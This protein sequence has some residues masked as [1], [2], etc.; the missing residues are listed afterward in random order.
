VLRRTIGY[1]DAKVPLENFDKAIFEV[2]PGGVYRLEQKL[3]YRSR[4]QIAKSTHNASRF[5]DYDESVL[6]IS[7]KYLYWC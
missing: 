1:R 3:E 4:I 7:M 5:V 2:S 6:V